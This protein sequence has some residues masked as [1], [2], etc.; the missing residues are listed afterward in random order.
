M[1]SFSSPEELLKFFKRRK[2]LQLAVRIAST[3]MTGI[4]LCAVVVLWKA[5]T[6]Y[7][8][9]HENYALQTHH[10]YVDAKLLSFYGFDTTRADIKTIIGP[11]SS[12]HPSNAYTL[13]SLT[14]NDIQSRDG[15]IIAHFTRIVSAP[16]TLL[17]LNPARYEGETAIAN[18]AFYLLV[19]IIGIVFFTVRN[20][21]KTIPISKHIKTFGFEPINTKNVEQLAIAQ[22]IINKVLTDL[23][24][25]FK[26]KAKIRDDLR[27]RIGRKIDADNVAASYKTAVDLANAAHINFWEALEIGKVFGYKTFKK[28]EQYY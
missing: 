27:K 19:Q 16:G 8:K 7:Q 25:D 22:P 11:P 26:T 9:H 6:I 23:A 17:K 24:N 4:T 20:K 2:W 13:N 10:S 5:Q 21:N 14:E 3:L 18:F 12:I 15:T 1:K 28:I